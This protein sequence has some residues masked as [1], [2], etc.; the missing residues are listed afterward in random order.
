[1]TD[2]P[3]TS[4]GP[5]VG[6]VAIEKSFR[7]GDDGTW[8]YDCVMTWC[9]GCKQLHPFRIRGPEP[10]WSWDGNLAAPTFEPSYLTWAG[11]SRRCHS[12][13]RAGRWEFLGDCTHELAGQTVDMVP[14][15]GWLLDDGAP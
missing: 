11:E 9:P 5:A 7:R 8:L 13:L 10:T 1:M 15:P 2:A 6:P 14:L 3:A 4:P 12:F